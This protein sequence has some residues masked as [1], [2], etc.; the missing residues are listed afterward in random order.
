MTYLDWAATAPQQPPCADDFQLGN[1][2]SAHACGQRQRH[3]LDAALD[4]IG[5]AF[6]RPAE[7]IVGTAGATEADH[8][9]LY[10]PLTHLR[11]SR[12]AFRRGIVHSA[13]EHPAV[14]EPV[15]QLGLMGF[16]TRT[17]R[18]GADGRI[19][20]DH[21][22]D[23]LDEHTRLVAIIAVNN[24]TGAIQPLGAAA[25]IVRAH[26]RR[27]G[28]R[29]HFHTDAVQA[30]CRGLDVPITAGDSAAASA[31]KIGGPVG[32]GALWLRDGAP[33][34][35]LPRGGGQQHGRRAGTE[36]VAGMRA[37]ARCAAAVAAATGEHPHRAARLQ[38]Q[39]TAGARRLDLRIIPRQRLDHPDHYSP[40]VTCL[41]AP[42]IPAEVL[43]R[44]LSD[45]DIYVS[46]GAACSSGK[47]RISPVL[48]AM[49]VP[50]EVA[51]GAFRVSI[52]WT[53]TEADVAR[54]LAGLGGI[55]PTLRAVAR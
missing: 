16:P 32:V 52:G 14:A 11:D 23:C 48:R 53:T 6:G 5:E 12:A 42:G 39:L 24:E 25:A 15:R 2:S 20:L 7:E 18:V 10:S 33:A 46:R 54:L 31:H 45:Q 21:L 47:H 37:F 36:N 28:R 1:P 26:A 34:E 27:I 49:G 22:A 43:V 40:Y 51:G 9:I 13:V 41:A 55:L 19:D 3:A 4:R 50:A 17:V 29:I 38:Q 44:M 30:L 35:P 8:L